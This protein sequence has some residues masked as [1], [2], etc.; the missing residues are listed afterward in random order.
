M[1]QAQAI[2]QGQR[3]SRRGRDIFFNGVS[4]MLEGVQLEWG[5]VRF[6]LLEMFREDIELGE[7]AF[8]ELHRNNPH[9]VR[10]MASGGEQ[11]L[12]GFVNFGSHERNLRARNVLDGRW[13]LSRNMG[14]LYGPGMRD[15]WPAPQHQ[16][17]PLPQPEQQ[18]QQPRQ[19][20]GLR[21]FL[22]QQA[23]QIPVPA[24]APRP[25]TPP[26]PRAR[27]PSPQP[28]VN[29]V[30]AGQAINDLME[31]LV[32][33]QTHVENERRIEREAEE[34]LRQ[35]AAR[36]EDDDN[37]SIITRPGTEKC[38]FCGQEDT[39]EHN[40]ACYEAEAASAIEALRMHLCPVCRVRI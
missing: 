20:G 18:Q 16:P 12:R 34:R 11:L 22:H 25:A 10:R 3:N 4:M 32:V 28:V 14:A 37:E 36:Q 9:N 30:A 21:A 40:E 39:E 6:L 5:E 19:M 31:A 29:E 38:H 33:A 26:I 23:P 13:F 2:N 7:P 35:E 8:F 24:P 15:D 17:P 1:A 27:T